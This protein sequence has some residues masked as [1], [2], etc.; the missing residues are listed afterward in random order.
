MIEVFKFA[1]E[2]DDKNLKLCVYMYIK[3]SETHKEAKKDKQK[4]IK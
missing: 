2:D 1:C 4:T 3:P